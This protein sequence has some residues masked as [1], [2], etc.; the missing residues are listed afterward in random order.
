MKLFDLFKKKTKTYSRVDCDYTVRFVKNILKYDT[1][2]EKEK[3]YVNF[4]H[5]R[6]VS[7]DLKVRGTK[8]YIGHSNGAPNE[9][10]LYLRC[11]YDKV[12]KEYVREPLEEL[13]S[14]TFNDYRKTDISGTAVEYCSMKTA[15]S[16]TTV[17]YCSMNIIDD[18]LS[19]HL[20]YIFEDV[21]DVDPYYQIFFSFKGVKD[22]DGRDV[23]GY[24]VFDRSAN[25]EFI[26]YLRK[27]S[28]ESSLDLQ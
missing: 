28:K 12:G 6:A 1:D 2:N 23:E 19:G 11:R 18:I 25:P 15:I 26:D 13:L 5:A 4:V 22:I 21:L 24:I 10:T 9:F 20:D 3:E 14:K 16:E 17:E 27:I 7:S 8:Y